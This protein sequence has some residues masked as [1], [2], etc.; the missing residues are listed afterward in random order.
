MPLLTN[1]ADA[2]PMSLRLYGEGTPRWTNATCH[3][4]LELA[5]SRSGA[6][7]YR[8]GRTEVTVPRGAVVVVPEG[9]D[10]R[11][12]M[13]EGGIAESLHLAPT[14]IA[15]LSDELGPRLVMRGLEP[16]VVHTGQVLDRAR[17]WATCGIPDA[18][19]L[20]ADGFVLEILRRRLQN[21]QL[22]EVRDIRISRALEL[23]WSDFQQAPQVEDLCDAA[24][25]SRFHFSRQFK[26]RTGKSPYR[27][28]LEVRLEHAAHLLRKQ[29]LSV[30]AAATTAGFTDLSRFSQLFRRHFG[31]SPKNYAKV[32]R[33]TDAPA[34]RPAS[35]PTSP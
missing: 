3:G 29:E 24:G 13:S 10:H 7:T 31:V 12:L 28:L 17:S 33:P 34:S 5:W 1:R 20:A 9:V 21:E 30:T 19:A 16:G 11:T 4:G 25:M 27:F 8:L 14:L 26:A 22:A 2:G 18:T 35:R 23:V 32:S 6:L 15:R